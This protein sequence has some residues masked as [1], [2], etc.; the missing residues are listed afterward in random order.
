MGRQTTFLIYGRS[1]CP[2]CVKAVDL[3]E[4]A[5]IDN[6]FFDLEDDPEFLEEAKRVYN[7][8]TVPLVLRIDGES[9]VANFIGGY[10]ELENYLND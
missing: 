9:G 7:H 5:G 6:H 4:F 10:T 8:K 1:S 3:L 2:F